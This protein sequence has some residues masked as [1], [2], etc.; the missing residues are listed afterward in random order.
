MFCVVAAV[1]CANLYAQNPAPTK[2]TIDPFKKNEEVKKE[3]KGPNIFQDLLDKKIEVPKKQSVPITTGSARGGSAGLSTG[4]KLPT[5]QTPTAQTKNPFGFGDDSDDPSDPFG[6]MGTSVIVKP[7]D[8]GTATITWSS[9]QDF[10]PGT[11]GSSGNPFGQSDDDSSANPFGSQ[12]GS[13]YTPGP[14]VS[15][16]PAGPMGMPNAGMMFDQSVAAALASLFK[17]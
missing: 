2:K 6:S 16:G 8:G 14:T 5:S 3:D 11:S 9:D 4:T 13:M 12:A 10:A 7:N 1:C 15:F 17:K